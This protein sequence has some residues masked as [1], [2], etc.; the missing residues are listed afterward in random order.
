MY[1]NC[2]DTHSL[3]LQCMYENKCWTQLSVSSGCGAMI[4][5]VA[6]FCLL[7]A[8]KQ[9]RKCNQKKTNKNKNDEYS[10]TPSGYS[11]KSALF[12]FCLP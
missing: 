2:F 6:M 4:L 11:L 9:I 5:L 3:E 12:L 10:E 7:T 1:C 8:C